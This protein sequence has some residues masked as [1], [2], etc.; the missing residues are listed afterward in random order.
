MWFTVEQ[1]KTFAALV[2]SVGVI[3]AAY[4]AYDLAKRLERHKYRIRVSE[5]MFTKFHEKRMATLESVL[6][7][8]GNVLFETMKLLFIGI[9]K[10]SPPSVDGESREKTLNREFEVRCKEI[11]DALIALYHAQETGRVYLPDTVYEDLSL[12]RQ[13]VADIVQKYTL[14]MVEPRRNDYFEIGDEARN[15][16]K[17]LTPKRDAT[18]KL[19][20]EYLEAID[21]PD[22]P[23]SVLSFIGHLRRSGSSTSKPGPSPLA[24][25]I[26]PDRQ[27]VAEN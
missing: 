24:S 22:E 13:E 1:V 12:F 21:Q 16:F 3:F 10:D 6:T 2:Q 19:V 18:V 15:R 23:G 17:A 7:L 5:I 14:K 4:L 9:P 25:R 26:A 11:N 8:Q 20:R 27:N